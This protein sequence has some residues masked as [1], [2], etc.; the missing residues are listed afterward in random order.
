VRADEWDAV[1]SMLLNGR[2]VFGG[3]SCLGASGDYDYPQAPFQ[4]VYAPEEIAED[5]PLRSKKLEAWQHWNDLKKQARE[6][7]YTLVTEYEDN[8]NVMLEPACAGGAC[9][10]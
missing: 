2:D 7:D 9:E 10:I 3:V 6:V 1:A 5:D 8:T 4:A